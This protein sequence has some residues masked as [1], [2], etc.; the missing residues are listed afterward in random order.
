VADFGG[1]SGSPDLALTPITIL[2]LLAFPPGE[3]KP[4][5]PGDCHR[6]GLQQ[7]LTKLDAPLHAVWLRQVALEQ[8]NKQTAQ[9]YSLAVSSYEKWWG[10]YQMQLH[11]EDLEW[12]TIPAFLSQW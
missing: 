11:A 9:T 5:G 10:Q 2:T 7:L 3:A 6:S 12:T 8:H 1:A 4:A